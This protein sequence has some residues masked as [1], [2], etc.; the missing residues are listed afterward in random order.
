[1]VKSGEISNLGEILDKGIKITSPTEFV[2]I[3]PTL[4]EM[5]DLKIPSSLDGKSLKPLIDGS[6]TEVKKYAVSQQPRGKD[7]LGYSFRTQDYRYTAWIGDGKKSTDNTISEKDIVA[8]ELYDYN[9]D[10][11]ETVNLIDNAK[12]SKIQI[13]LK[14]FA[15]E[16]FKSEYAKSHVKVG[17]VEVSDKSIKQILNEN[18]DTQKVFVGATLNHS[19]LNTSVSDLFLKEFTYTTPEN[20][21]KQSRVHPSPNKWDWS[22]IDAYLKFAQD[23]KITVRLHGPISPQASKWAKADERTA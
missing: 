9:T 10:P 16:F 12:Y 23:N 3:F 15:F 17:R 1:M 6:S 13:E 11:L 4:C 19:Q 20:C 5:T 8:Q 7:V 2:D 21:A 14:G 22:Q 18:Y